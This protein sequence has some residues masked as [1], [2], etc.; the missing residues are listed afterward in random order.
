MKLDADWKSAWLLGFISRVL[1]RGMYGKLL[2]QLLLVLVVV[3][4]MYNVESMPI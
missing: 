2:A 1:E 3:G 4:T